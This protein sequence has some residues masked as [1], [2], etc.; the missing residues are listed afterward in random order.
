MQLKNVLFFGLSLVLSLWILSNHSYADKPKFSDIKG[1]W[2]ENTILWAVGIGAINGYEDGSFKPDQELTEAEFVAMYVKVFLIN[3]DIQL[4]KPKEP[5]IPAEYQKLYGS[6]KDFE[7]NK[8]DTI[9]PEQLNHW[10]D[11]FYI[12]AIGK[13]YPL[14]GYQDIEKRNSFIHRVSVA[15]IIASSAGVN[16]SGDDAIQFVLGSNY[17]EGSNESNVTIENFNGEANLTRA[18]AIQLI[19][20]IKDM[21]TM[22]GTDSRPK[23]ASS[24]IALPDLPAKLDPLPSKII[25]ALKEKMRE[26]KFIDY[27]AG[28]DNETVAIANQNAPAPWEAHNGIGT[29][30]MSIPQSDGGGYILSLS[31]GGDPRLVELAILMLKTAGANLPSNLNEIILKMIKANNPN[32]E[33]NSKGKTFNVS[34]LQN[35]YQGIY[36]FFEL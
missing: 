28:A 24:K 19:K 23:S 33:Y 15:E 5:E 34:V 22:S 17:A 8:V 2:A 27:Y 18:E 13:N 31:D 21:R 36:I 25:K 14:D 4:V 9:P 29:L 26:S 16:Y 35:D 3:S 10:A 12:M 20:N 32:Q 11:S 30:F 6:I 1:H 7:E